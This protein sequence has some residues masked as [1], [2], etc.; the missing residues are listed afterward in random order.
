MSKIEWTEKT[1]NI[2]TGCTLLSAGCKNCYAEAMAKRLKAMG[3]ERYKN[4]FNLTLQPDMILRPLSWKKP[5]MI[6]VNSMSDLFHADVPDEYIMRFISMAE[7]A[8]HHIFQVL[9]KRSER[10]ANFKLRWPDNVWV[11]VSCEHPRYSF[12][13]DHLRLVNAATKFVSCEPLLA[14]LADLNFSGIGWVI[15]GGESGPKA[16]PMYKSWVVEIKSI[17]FD[18][19][20]PF[21]FKQWGGTNKK[22]AGRL[23]DGK[24]YMEFPRAYYGWAGRRDGNV[25]APH[26]S[27]LKLL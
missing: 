3:Q 9:T 16:R 13:L 17:C 22:K 20:I 18:L 26:S 25:Q 10:L 4:G 14:S 8:R 15:V 24:E 23:L 27:Q 6:F 19:G 12:R 1:L 5:K 21:F 2:S 11:G 7:R